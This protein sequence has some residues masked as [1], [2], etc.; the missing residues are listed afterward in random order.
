MYKQGDKSHVSN[1]H[2]I[3]ILSALSKVFKINLKE[4]ISSYLNKINFSTKYQFR[5]RANHLTKHTVAALL[6]EINDGFHVVTVF[7]DVKKAFDTLNYEIL[8]DKLIN[9][10]IRGKEL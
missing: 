1:Y 4:R 7:Y 8:L 6:L 9:S 10:S 3:A 2:P 5:F